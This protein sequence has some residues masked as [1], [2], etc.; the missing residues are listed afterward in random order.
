MEAEYVALSQSM[1]DLIPTWELL[2]E[3]MAVIFNV[4]DMIQYC[5]YSKAFN[6]V[7]NI[8]R[9]EDESQMPVRKYLQ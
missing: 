3:L 5:T 7:I 2:K 8:V 1:R 4:V 9:P 6:D